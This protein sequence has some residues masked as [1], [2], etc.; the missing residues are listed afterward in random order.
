M[1]A[2]IKE[3]F[4]SPFHKSNPASQYYDISSY[5]KTSHADSLRNEFMQSDFPQQYNLGGVDTS[6][7]NRLPS[8]NP[9]NRYPTMHPTKDRSLP[10]YR[11]SDTDTIST[12]TASLCKDP[13][14]G[15]GWAVPHVPS[16]LAN[17]QPKYIPQPGHNFSPQPYPQCI[18]QPRDVPKVSP[19]S[20]AIT[21]PFI[22]SNNQLNQPSQLGQNY[23]PNQMAQ[24]YRQKD[25]ECEQLVDRV[26][27]NTKCR[28]MLKNLLNNPDNDENDNIDIKP[29]PPFKKA[30]EGFYGGFPPVTQTTN[31]SQETIKTMLVYGLGGLLILCV[32]DLFVKL[33][34][35]LGN[36]K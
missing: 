5:T 8:F 36:R 23:N 16:Y 26:L 14:Q 33:G 15:A 21:E 20:P 24:V 22:Y 1:P 31:F 34:Q 27:S 10:D 29:L 35:I 4:K 32:L 3:A 30:T 6:N 28:Q 11:R 19:T 7:P 18:P 2:G 13:N 12:S 25:D 17:P 9:S